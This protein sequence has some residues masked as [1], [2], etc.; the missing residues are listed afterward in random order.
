[1]PSWFILRQANKLSVILSSDRV[2]E[3]LQNAM[4]S[5]VTGLP[6]FRFDSKLTT[7]LTQIAYTRAIDALRAGSR[8]SQVLPLQNHSAEDEEQEVIPDRN[9]LTGTLEEEC[10]TTEELREVLAE[11]SAYIDSRDKPERN[12]KIAE[13]V[14]L[15]GYSLEE[16]AREV[17][18][19]SAVASYVIRTLRRHLVEKFRPSSSSE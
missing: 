14:L 9:K 8:D 10:I 3:I 7:W 19:S 5:V 17:G 6:Y 11:I 2:D 1:M 13:M 16:T 4:L 12:H 18:V 15:K